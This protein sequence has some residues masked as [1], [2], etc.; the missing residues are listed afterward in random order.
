V[1]RGSTARETGLGVDQIVGEFWGGKSWE[2]IVRHHNADLETLRR[3][4]QR[5]PESVDQPSEDRGPHVG[6]CRARSA[7]SISDG[8]PFP[9]SPNDPAR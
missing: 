3:D 6:E 2:E 4:V 7:V 8:N 9:R 5:S 1:E